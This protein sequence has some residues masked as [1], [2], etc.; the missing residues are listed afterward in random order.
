M[1]EAH[2][3]GQASGAAAA[4]ALAAAVLSGDTR[5]AARACRLVDDVR[6]GHAELLAALYER[7]TASWL[8]GVTG[9]PG[10]GKSTLTSRLV[11]H[12]RAQGGRVAVVAVDPSSPFS[13]GAI[14]GDRIRMQAHWSDPDVFVRSVATRGAHGGLSRTTADI[15][16]VLAAWGARVVL[17]E[18]VGVGQDELDVMRVADTTLVVQ[19]PGAGDDI[20]AAKAGL[21]ECADVF[22]V[23]KA[24]LPGADNV[25]E[26]L[27]SMLAL[28][29]VTA[30]AAWSAGSRGHSAASLSGAIEQHAA[31]DDW[32]V[33]VLPC[34][35]TRDEGIE[36]LVEQLAAHHRWCTGSALGLAQR[37]ERLTE[38]LY[39]RVREALVIEMLERHR[40]E[41]DAI[42]Q[43]V[44]RGELDPYAAT[45]VLLERWLGR[46][47]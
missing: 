10:V 26:N 24:D 28:G 3:S 8:I 47:A 46:P 38:E 43:Q 4:A 33:P 15:A 18:T 45:R 9:S 1:S 35:A 32:Q 19:A 17:I 12:F 42:A 36:P 29:A 20:Q 31:S 23:N 44:Q 27:R 14:L 22:A 40:S 11:Q 41:L 6:P 16:R 34:V 37:R 7:S 30:S 39:G 25:A 2:D 5:A 13:G 21:L